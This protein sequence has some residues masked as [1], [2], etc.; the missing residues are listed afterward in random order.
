[1]M[2]VRSFLQPSSSHPPPRPGYP[3]RWCPN[4]GV[5]CP[6]GCPSRAAPRLVLRTPAADAARPPAPPLEPQ[7]RLLAA[8]AAAPAPTRGRP[9]PCHWCRTD[10]HLESRGDTGCRGPPGGRRCGGLQGP[11]ASVP[12]FRD[13]Q[14]QPSSLTFLTP[15]FDGDA[16]RWAHEEG[17]GKEK[18]NPHLLSLPQCPGHATLGEVPFSQAESTNPRPSLWF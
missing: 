11:G 13:C 4:V 16:W 8:A 3:R 17:S 12:F 10:Y 6:S 7:A 9:P 14:D 18:G 2:S 5:P 15:G 1:M